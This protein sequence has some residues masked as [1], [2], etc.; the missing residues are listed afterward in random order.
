MI[1]INQFSSHSLDGL[2][3]SAAG[4]LKYVDIRKDNA[5]TTQNFSTIVDIR[6]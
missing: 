2:P 1:L 5:F 4:A 3:A 6:K